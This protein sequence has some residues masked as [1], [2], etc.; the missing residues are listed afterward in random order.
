MSWSCFRTPIVGVTA[1]QSHPVQPDSELSCITFCGCTQRRSRSFWTR[2]RNAEQCQGM[3]GHFSIVDRP[4]ELIKVKGMQAAPA[5]VEGAL[6]A[7]EL[8]YDASCRG[9]TRAR[10]RAARRLRRAARR[11]A[12]L[13]GPRRR[14]YRAAA[15]DTGG[16]ARLPRRALA[17]CKAPAEVPFV[18]AGETSKAASGKISCG[19]RCATSSAPMRRRRRRRRRRRA[20]KGCVGSSDSDRAV[21]GLGGSRSGGG[22]RRARERRRFMALTARLAPRGAPLC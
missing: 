11:A 10:G 4:E 15:A 3:Y 1:V 2:V 20:G 21:G 9:P 12:A 5:E 8:A 16:A 18:E 7:H 14:G 19:A 13:A 17:E 6:M 22:E